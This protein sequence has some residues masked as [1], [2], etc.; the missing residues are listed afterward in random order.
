MTCYT[1]PHSGLHSKS[2]RRTASNLP[3]CDLPSDGDRSLILLAQPPNLCISATHTLSQRGTWLSTLALAGHG[4][5]D[6][7]PCSYSIRLGSASK[8][9]AHSSRC[10][11]SRQRCPQATS[12]TTEATPRGST[13]QR[14]ASSPTSG[15]CHTEAP[16]P[17][18]SPHAPPSTPA[19]RRSP[20][21]PQRS[22]CTRPPPCSH[23]FSPPPVLAFN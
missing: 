15:A 6:L 4:T 7:S 18:A 13:A 8:Q 12:A 19:P 22:H 14:N 17:T 3:R 23:H 10:Q 1:S 2:E 9:S 20:V 11:P 21:R 16:S 5:L